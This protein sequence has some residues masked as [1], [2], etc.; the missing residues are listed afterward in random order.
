MTA[1]PYLTPAGMPAT[2]KA[3]FFT[4]QG[5]VSQGVFA[6]LN[7][8][9]GKGDKDKNIK[10]NRRRICETMGVD[11]KSM[12]TLNQVHSDTVITVEKHL[13]TPKKG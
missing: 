10:E 9:A 8:S 3:G 11:L 5:G 12:I 2:V 1:V 4:R 6:S 7:V 13:K